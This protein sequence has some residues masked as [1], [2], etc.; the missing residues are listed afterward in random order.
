MVTLS[1]EK[2]FRLYPFKNKMD[3]NSLEQIASETYGRTYTV[4]ANPYE[5][6]SFA[7]DVLLEYSYS[8]YKLQGTEQEDTESFDEW[9]AVNAWNAKDNSPHWRTMLTRLIDDKVLP[10]GKY[11]LDVS[12]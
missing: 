2:F 12:W 11:L 4:F 10:E 9:M 5:D 8:N 3:P 1:E 7:N 6:E